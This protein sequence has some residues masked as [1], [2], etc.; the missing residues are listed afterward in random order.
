LQATLPSPCQP[1]DRRIR[2]AAGGIR[3]HIWWHTVRHWRR[4]GGWFPRG[5]AYGRVAVVTGGLME[6]DGAEGVV[7]PLS[8]GGRR[9]TSA[10]GRAV[11]SD[12]LRPVDPA[13]A[14]GAERETN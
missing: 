8:A 10:L 9:S 5:G 11:V 6:G 2:C 3:S 1:S 12:A 13:G 7:F 4:R 14:V